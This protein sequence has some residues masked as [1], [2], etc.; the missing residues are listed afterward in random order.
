[1]GLIHE[2]SLF[3]LA[4]GPKQKKKKKKKKKKKIL[5]PHLRFWIQ[6]KKKSR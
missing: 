2:K 1:M 6:T 4:F 3:I 5:T